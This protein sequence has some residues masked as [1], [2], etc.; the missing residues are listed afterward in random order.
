MDIY[1]PKHGESDQHWFA[2][3]ANPHSWLMTAD[4]LFEQ[5]ARLHSQNGRG[6]IG[7]KDN[8]GTNLAWD[9]VDRSMFLLGGFAI[10]NAIK[11]FLV[12]E[13]PHFVSDARLAKE[14][15]SH[16]LVELKRKA[17]TIP[18]PKRSEA[19]LA[20]FEEGL[21]TW[22]RY[23]CGLNAQQTNH[24]QWFTPELWAAYCDLMRRYGRKLQKHLENGWAGPHDTGGK[25]TF[26]GLSFLD[27]DHVSL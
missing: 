10:E 5:C 13:N 24:Q 8:R 21:E 18:M 20:A 3:M 19:I 22:S 4:N 9:V 23:P 12:Y 16:R 2:E 1:Q 11:A 6:R 25:W 7:F 27:I 14:L 17:L 15:R 26:E